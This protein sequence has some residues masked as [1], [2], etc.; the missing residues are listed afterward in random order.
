MPRAVR[1]L[2]AR[3]RRDAS[4]DTLILDADQRRVQRGR[5]VGERGTCVEFDLPAPIVLRTDDTILL[6]DG[7]MV[8]VVA[9]AESLWEIRA[10]VVSLARLAWMLGDRHVQIEILA[11]RIRLRRDPTL[12]P[13]LA[14][15]GAAL[16]AID[17]PFEPEGG[18]YTPSAAEHHHHTNEPAPASGSAHAHRH[19]HSH[20][21]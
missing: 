1:I 2:A 9:R 17:A 8:E 12:E 15:A 3:D 5:V 6:D 16:A 19:A 7:S 13:L 10:D 21:D 4:V 14:T 11:N 18:A 20:T